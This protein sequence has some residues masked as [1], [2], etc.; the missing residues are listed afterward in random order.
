MADNSRI[1]RRLVARSILV[2]GLLSIILCSLSAFHI[3]QVKASGLVF[4]PLQ[5]QWV[6]KS[7]PKK[8]E[9]TPPLP[10]ICAAVKG[11]TAFVE[12]LVAG[13]G[14][15]IATAG[16]VDVSELFF[17]FVAKGDKAFSEIPSSPD[18]PKMPLTVVEKAQGGTNV[19]R[20]GFLAVN[21]RTFS[22]EQVSRPPTPK[23][24]SDFNSPQ[25]TG[26]QSVAYAINTRG[27]PSLT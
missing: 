3:G 4:C 6:K 20:S 19:V 26:L 27:P 11:K 9:S 8:A 23:S 25:I 14:S 13:V 18:L 24:V 5:K 21:T 16:K 12:K 7:E 22:F 1:L 17:S 10:D 15:R 2:L